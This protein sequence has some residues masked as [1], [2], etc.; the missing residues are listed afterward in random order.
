MEE[1]Y[2]SIK[3]YENYEISN[4]GN[5]RNA[6]QG[7]RSKIPTL[8]TNG[9]YVIILYKNN[10]GNKKYIHRLIAE[11][12]IENP[13]NKDCV[14]HI[15]RNKQNNNLNNL[16]WA[17]HSEN[18]MNIM[19]RKNNTSSKTGVQYY[20]RTK[21]WVA[22]IQIKGVSKYIGHFNNFEDAVNARS[23]NEKIY[24]KEFRAL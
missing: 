13:E 5:I 16:R 19:T 1:E 4:L 9:Y 12:F 20:K 18:H 2:K 14:D 23:E 24:F 3:E 15:D 10:K 6:K 11:S 22:S 17:T 21:Q 7:N 8:D